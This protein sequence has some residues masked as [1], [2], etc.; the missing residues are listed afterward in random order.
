MKSTPF[1][2]G[3]Y[4]RIAKMCVQVIKGSN[5]E[6]IGHHKTEALAETGS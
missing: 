3:T 4:K 2:A 6:P 5:D 1:L